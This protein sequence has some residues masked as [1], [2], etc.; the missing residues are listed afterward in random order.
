MEQGSVVQ[1]RIPEHTFRDMDP[2]AIPS[3]RELFSSTARERRQLDNEASQ[4]LQG[5]EE[6]RNNWSYAV[7]TSARGCIR[8]NYKEHRKSHQNQNNLFHVFHLLFDVNSSTYSILQFMTICNS[9][10]IYPQPDL[11]LYDTGNKVRK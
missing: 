3:A 7:M 1:A 10:T 6:A 5:T 4:F 9:N 8:W 2:T 11:T